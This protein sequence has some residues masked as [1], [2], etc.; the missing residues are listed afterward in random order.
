M[1]SCGTGVTACILAMVISYLHPSLLFETI[2]C[3]EESE[4]DVVAFYVR[5]FTEWEKLMCQS[6]MARGLNGQHNQTCLWKGRILLHEQSSRERLA[7]RLQA[8]NTDDVF[9]NLRMNISLV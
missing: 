8:T 2:N 1:A 3:V 9:L 4:S 6:T 7:T 5:G